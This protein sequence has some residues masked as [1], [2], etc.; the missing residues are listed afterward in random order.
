MC[1]WSGFP[2]LPVI[3]LLFVG[4]SNTLL[5]YGPNNVEYFLQNVNLEHVHS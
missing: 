3:V 2:I 5:V 4:S 1:Q